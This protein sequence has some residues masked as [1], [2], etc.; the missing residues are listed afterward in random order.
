MNIKYVCI[1]LFLAAV[2]SGCKKEDNCKKEEDKPRQFRGELHLGD[3]KGDHIH[4][5]WW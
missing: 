3:E 4:I 2:L 1:I 5:E